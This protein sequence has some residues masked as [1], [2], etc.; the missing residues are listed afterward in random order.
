MPKISNPHPTKCPKCDKILASVGTWKNHMTKAH[1]GYDEEMLQSAAGSQPEGAAA[2]GAESLDQVAATM[3]ESGEAFRLT[4]PDAVPGAPRERAAKPAAVNKAI[5]ANLQEVK[6]RLA[7]SLPMIFGHWINATLERPRVSDNEMKEKC[8][9]V[10]EAIQTVL[11]ALG[12]DIQIEPMNTVIRSRLWLIFI[13]LGALLA[14]FFSELMQYA[15][16][17]GKTEEEETSAIDTATP[18]SI[19][20]EDR[21]FRSEPG[22]A[23]Q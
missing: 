1:G 15:A 21:D 16:T 2:G 13:P 19:A 6:R 18:E 7:E 5:A 17:F 20:Q 9:P 10:T 12:V 8:K 11:N 22:N 23:P 3:P 14:V 4:P